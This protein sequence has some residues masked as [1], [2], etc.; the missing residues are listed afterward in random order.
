[1]AGASPGWTDLRDLALRAEE[2]GFDAAWLP[3]HFIFERPDGRR[4][5]VWEA[6]S[7][8]A[9]LAA[10]T[11][12]IRLGTLV[13]GGGFRN[14]ALLAKMAD[15]VDE[16]SGGRLVLGIGAGWNEAEYRAFGYPYDHR[17]SR[18]EEAIQIIAGLLR[19][20]RAD[21]HG[22][23][24]RADDAELLPRGPR[25]GGP[26]IMVGTLSP[27][28]MRIA[29]RYADWW[30]ADW[31]RTPEEL[32]PYVDMV[33]EACAEVGREPSSLVRTASVLFD[34]P[35]AGRR[36][37]QGPRTRDQPSRPQDPEEI[38]A[39]LQGY[40]ALGVAEVVAWIDPFTPEGI[41][42]FQPV[43]ALLDRR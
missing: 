23:Y 29:A 33:D 3:D 28:M 17:V 1:M 4:V 35:G 20:G 6:W 34:L 16:I 25:P 39:T 2:A 19:T 37:G 30:N 40:A 5:G 32:K 36:G 31:T 9:A 43:L 14:P 42:S 38:A 41:A 12:R 18:F 15:T 8:L 27:R 13:L 26:P 11:E 7:L 24:Y 22:R 10:A 21:F